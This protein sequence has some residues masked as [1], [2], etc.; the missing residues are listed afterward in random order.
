[1]SVI[2]SKRN[3]AKT[4]YIF[5]FF[6]LSKYTEERIK[7]VPKRKYRWLA[8]D[9]IAT[10]H[11]IESYLM[12]IEND[13][14]KYGIKLKDKAGQAQTVIETFES[15]QKPLL[16]L[17]NIEKYLAEKDA[18]DIT[19][20]IINQPYAAMKRETDRGMTLGSQVSQIM[21]LIIA[22]S[23]D[24]L[25]KDVLRVKHYLRHMDDGILFARTKDELLEIL[26][27]ISAHCG[28]I[29]LVI[30]QRK[31]KIV[32]ALH[33]FT[34]LKIKYNILKSGKIL[35][36]LT[37]AGIVR[38]RRKYKKLLKK[39]I[40]GELPYRCVYDS[41]QSWMSHTRLAQAYRTTKQMIALTGD[42]G[43][44]RR[45]EENVLQTHIREKYIWSCL[46]PGFPQV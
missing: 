37:H 12:Q 39:H 21:A 1:M 36:R 32:K 43:R 10:M 6:D 17:W 7:K 33:G 42:V 5:T 30:N 15:L 20:R 4:Q 23:L 41:V 40:S 18:V 35:Q 2:A 11:L 22:N 13:Y 26:K 27:K 29:G 8:Q 19:M 34:F 45:E 31:T 38:M 46:Q 3:V 14:Y 28:K 25:L 9:I 16:A 24:H 44:K